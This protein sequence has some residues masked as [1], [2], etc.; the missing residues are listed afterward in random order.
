MKSNTY[1][2][3]AVIFDMGN[4]VLNVDH[5][6][7]CKKLS[8]F[9]NLSK[10]KIYKKIIGTRLEDS[11]ER[12]II[13]PHTFYKSVIERI[14]ADISFNSFSSIYNDVFTTNNGMNETIIKLK[15][16]VKILLLSNTNK[17]HFSWVNERFDILK[18]FNKR[19]LSYETGSRKPEKEIFLHALDILKYQP[20]EIIY[21]D[22]VPGFVE[23]SK[24]LGMNTILFKSFS[25]FKFDLLRYFP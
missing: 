18:N 14:D 21:I 3:K 5:M 2:I 19:V 1:S 8:E 17:L 20:D 11:F 24:K 16:K 22:D 7:A 23:A 13:S 6:V 15:D 4:V 10:E 9:S 12:G 25:M